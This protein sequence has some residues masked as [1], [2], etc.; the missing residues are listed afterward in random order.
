[1]PD[2]I[3]LNQLESHLW[4]AANILRGPVDAADFKS[5]VFPLLFFK[6]ISDVHDEEYRAALEE[7]GGMR[8]TTRFPQNYRFQVPADRHWNVVVIYLPTSD[9]PSACHAGH[10]KANPETLYGIFGDAQWTRIRRSLWVRMADSPLGQSARQQ[11]SAVRRPFVSVL[12]RRCDGLGTAQLGPGLRDILENQGHEAEAAG[13][14]QAAKLA[15]NHCT[16]AKA[17]GEHLKGITGQYQISYIELDKDLEVDKVCDIFT[18]INSRGVRLDVFDLVNALLKPKGLQLKQMWRDAAPRLDDVET[19][20]MNVYILQVMSILR[21][22]YCSPKYLYFL[23]ARP[24]EARPRPRWQRRKEILIPDIADFE[25]RGTP[26]SMPW[27]APSRCCN[28]RRSMA[29]SVPDF[30]PYVSIL[31]VFAALACP[32]QDTSGGP[33]TRRPPQA[34]P[35]VLGLRLQQPLFRL[36]RI[37]QRPRFPRPE[38]VVR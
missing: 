24:G 6:R 14:E 18:Q 8:N 28:I 30:L 3:T 26:Q 34:P 2:G 15:Q 22:G 13:D 11:G 37:H 38:S 23:L 27:K 21:Q 29:R 10:R 20:K 25:S 5:Y 7:S 36:G 32:R 33:P 16:N 4:E 12:R 31:P 1:M 17:F 35:L 9:R 19:E